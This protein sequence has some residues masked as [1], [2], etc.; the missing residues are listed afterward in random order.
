LFVLLPLLSSPA[1]AQPSDDGNGQLVD[2]CQARPQEDQE[3]QLKAAGQLP[4]DVL[5][6][7]FERCHGVLKPP[8]TGDG[9][10]VEPA[11]DAGTT[12]IIPPGSLP[13]QP[14]K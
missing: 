13:E 11:P 4:D 9:E 6:E 5:S 3:R 12:P 1:A 2:P 7:S 10:I 14:P 8:P